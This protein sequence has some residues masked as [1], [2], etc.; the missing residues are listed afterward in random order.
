MPACAQHDGS[1]IEEFFAVTISTDTTS[2]SMRQ[3]LEDFM[4]APRTGVRRYQ[5]DGS[6]DTSGRRM[7]TTR[8]R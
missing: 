5:M 7:R 6:N 4:N 1:Y 3:W 8:C 2:F